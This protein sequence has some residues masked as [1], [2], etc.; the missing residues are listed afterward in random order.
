MPGLKHSV[1]FHPPNILNHR[2]W[3]LVLVV[4]PILTSL[5][6]LMFAGAVISYDGEIHQDEFTGLDNAITVAATVFP[7]LFA[8]LVG[9]L[10]AQRAHWKLERDISLNLLKQ[11]LGSRTVFEIPLAPWQLRQ[12][13]A[14]AIALLLLWACSAAGTQAKIGFGAAWSVLRC[15]RSCRHLTSERNGRASRKWL[16]RRD[17]CE[18]AALSLS[19]SRRK[20]ALP[21]ISRLY[22]FSTSLLGCLTICPR[23]LD[24]LPRLQ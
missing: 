7:I 1:T 14:V 3:D 24:P 10:T 8:A 23:H 16:T 6:F 2:I 17:Q 15:Q 11:L 20:C 4:I 19:A 5:P 13:H 12:L 18:T 21:T 9:C 22:H